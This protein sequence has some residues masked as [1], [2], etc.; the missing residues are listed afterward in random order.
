[1]EIAFPVTS[2]KTGPFM[3]G[4]VYKINSGEEKYLYFIDKHISYFIFFYYRECFVST[5]EVH[6]A[7]SFVK[8]ASKVH[9]NLQ[10]AKIL[11]TKWS[12]YILNMSRE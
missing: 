1:M 5:D 7:C 12:L 11:E 9:P 3:F 6:T 8:R 4:Y 10:S 2:P